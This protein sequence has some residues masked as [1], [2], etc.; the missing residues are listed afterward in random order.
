MSCEY[1]SLDC[2]LPDF[3]FNYVRILFIYISELIEEHK[4]QKVRV[5]QTQRNW[6]AAKAAKQTTVD[7]LT[8]GIVNYKYLGLDFEKADH[9]RLRYVRAIHCTL[10]K[11]KA[12][13]LCT[14]VPP[15]IGCL[16]CAQIYF[17][18]YVLSLAFSH[19]RFSFTQLDAHHPDRKFSFELAA[20]DCDDRWTVAELDPPGAVAPDR[21]EELLAPLNDTNDMMPFVRG[22]RRAFL[23]SIH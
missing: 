5:Q 7:D 17:L 9:E 4:Q 10:S 12:S 3:L 15:S 20:T 22:M 18:F 1:C 21:L 23:E 6:D 16:L 19:P 13:L 14:V 8:R 2:F 11:N